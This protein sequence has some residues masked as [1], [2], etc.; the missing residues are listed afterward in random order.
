VKV[1]AL[2]AALAATAALALAACGSSTTSGSSAGQAHSA[3]GTP[4][5]GSAST[6]AAAATAASTNVCTDL[7]AAV[8]T[9]LTG[10]KFTK[11]KPSSVQNTVFGC[12]YDGPNGALLHITVQTKYGKDEFSTDISALKAVRH[13]PDSVAGVG[14]EAFSEPDPRGNAGSVGA[15]AFASYG[16]VFGDMYIKIGGLTYVTASQGR[17][18]VERLHGKI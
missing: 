15:S 1:H 14:D 13:A 6:Q 2:T 11:A 4:A 7:S 10:T 9:Q 17:Q 3:S 16:A 18:L 5:A 12:E 8:A